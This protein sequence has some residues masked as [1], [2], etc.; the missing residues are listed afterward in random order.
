[1]F[2]MMTSLTFAVVNV[3]V[4]EDELTDELEKPF[5]SIASVGVGVDLRAGL[6]QAG[7]RQVGG[8]AGA[9]GDGRAD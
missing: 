1:M 9:V 2:R 4:A 6:G 7:Q 3:T 8:I 5:P